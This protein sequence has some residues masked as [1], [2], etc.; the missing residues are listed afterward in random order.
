M[1][2]DHVNNK[3]SLVDITY[4]NTTQYS[5]LWNTLDLMMAQYKGQNMLSM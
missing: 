5:L 3:N 4:V 1:I 2:I